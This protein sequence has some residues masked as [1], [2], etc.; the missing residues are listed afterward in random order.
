MK[1]SS[2]QYPLPCRHLT[3]I[4]TLEKKQKAFDKIVEDWKKKTDDIQREVDA[5]NRDA[6][7]TN[8]EVREDYW[9]YEE[10]KEGESNCYQSQWLCS[11][12]ET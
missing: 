9:L 6:R 7:N 1:W 4:A 3:T 8:T 12:G 10:G 5:A 11:S 2:I